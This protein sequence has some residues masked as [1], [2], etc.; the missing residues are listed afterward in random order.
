MKCKLQ[1]FHKEQFLH[2]GEGTVCRYVEKRFILEFEQKGKKESG[3][4]EFIYNRTCV[5]MS[6]KCTY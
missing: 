3:A 1:K 2:C 6:C 4:I 5:Y